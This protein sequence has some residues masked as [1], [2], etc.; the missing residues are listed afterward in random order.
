MHG[1]RYMFLP[2]LY[3]EQAR[4]LREENLQ[5]LDP[6]LRPANSAPASSAEKGAAQEPDL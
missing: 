5:Y 3:D 2:F 6:E 1:R 4:R